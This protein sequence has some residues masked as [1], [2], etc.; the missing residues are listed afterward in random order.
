MPPSLRPSGSRA[1]SSPQVRQVTV[2]LSSSASVTSSR[3]LHS[4]QRPSVGSTRMAFLR[5]WGDSFREHPLALLDPESAGLV[6]GVKRP[7]VDEGQAFGVGDGT[8]LAGGDEAHG[9]L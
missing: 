6:F 8:G 7:L 4:L 3:P 2:R 1:Y 9:L 5:R